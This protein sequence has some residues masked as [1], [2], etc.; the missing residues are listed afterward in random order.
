MFTR[1]FTA[2][3]PRTSLTAA[4]LG[5]GTL[6]LAGIAGDSSVD[7]RFQGLRSK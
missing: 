5:S 4:A 6:G 2:S 1:R 3:A 7:E